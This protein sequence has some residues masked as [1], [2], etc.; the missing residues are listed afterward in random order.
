MRNPSTGQ[1]SFSWAA[2]CAPSSSG[3]TAQ[4]GVTARHLNPDSLEGIIPGVMRAP[5]ACGNR[6]AISEV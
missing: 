2:V 5:T 6:V 3:P 4:G 1:D